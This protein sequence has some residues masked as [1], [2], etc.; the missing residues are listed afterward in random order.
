MKVL[1]QA[2]AAALLAAT[3]LVGPGNRVD[4]GWGGIVNARRYAAPRHC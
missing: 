2:S 3:A 1:S 4:T